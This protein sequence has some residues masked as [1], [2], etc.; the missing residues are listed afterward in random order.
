MNSKNHSIVIS[1]ILAFALMAG[2][3]ISTAFVNVFA[4]EGAITPEG[5]INDTMSG[6]NATQWA[7]AT[8]AFAQEG[9]TTEDLVNETI[10]LGNDT[11]MMN[12]TLAFAQENDTGMTSE[13]SGNMTG[14][15]QGQT[16][17]DDG[18]DGGNDDGD[19]EEDKDED[20][21]EGE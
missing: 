1:S 12:A 15:T 19:S 2:A 4:Q 20:K 13:G 11:T 21:D 16:D 9:F 8:L 10:D 14:M 5:S 18:D 7:N 6:E 17:D 3:G